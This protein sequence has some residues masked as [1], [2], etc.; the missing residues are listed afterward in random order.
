MGATDCDGLC[1]G[2]RAD[3][4]KFKK[5]THA[6]HQIV[7]FLRA[8]RGWDIEGAQAHAVELSM[9]LDRIGKSEN[10]LLLDRNGKGLGDNRSSVQCGRK[11]RVLQVE[12]D[13]PVGEAVIELDRDS[14]AGGD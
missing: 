13:A 9:I 11:I 5:R 6:I 4:P 3:E 7:E 8:A 12:A 2:T 14:E 1:V 10:L